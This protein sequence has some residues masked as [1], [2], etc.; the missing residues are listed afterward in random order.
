MNAFKVGRRR[1]ASLAPWGGLAGILIAALV[2][3]R[4][5]VEP[6]VTPEPSPETRPPTVI[7][8]PVAPPPPPPPPPPPVPTGPLLIRVGL[9]SDL[10]S[11]DLACCD[12]QLTL[13]VGD[14]TMPLTG[15]ASITAAGTVTDR[16]VFRLQVAALKDEL[17]AQGLAERLAESTGHE[18]DAVF[19][20]GT[21]L[22]RV[23]VGR[24]AER[25]P[26][27]EGRR[28][29]AVLGLRDVWIA[30]EGGALENPA[31]EIDHDG[32]RY[33]VAGRWLEVSAAEDVGVPFDDNRY[34]GRLL[35]FL[36]S[37]GGLNVVNELK[38]EDYLR[39]VVPKEMG[40]ELYN[41]LEALKAQTVAARTYVVRNLE[42]FAEEGFDICS[43]PRCQVYGGMKVEHP[44]SDRA[45]A[46]T[47]G[48]VVLF[49]GEPA[50]TLYGAT[51][52]GHTE[53]VEVIFPLKNGPYLR[54]TPCLES[55]TNRLAG[56]LP[57]GTPFPGALMQRLVPA[58]RGKPHR[59]LAHRIEQLARLAGLS[60]PRDRLRSLERREVLRF[61]TSVYD[62]AL[63]RRLRS[64]PEV[65]K[66]LLT[67]P[68][69]DLRGRDREL[70]SFLVSSTLLQDPGSETV[71]D[72]EREQLLFR[73]ALY[74]GV[75]ERRSGYFLK[76]SERRLDMRD[77]AGRRASDLPAGLPT[78][79]RQGEDLKAGALELMAGD[80]LDLYLHQGRP[81]A[82]VQPEEVHSVRFGSRAP[83]QRWTR[84]SSTRKLKAAVQ[85]R[86]PGFPFEDFEVL[87]RGVSGRVAK[88]RLLGTG[89]QTL[90]VEG[91]AVRWTLDVWD[92][93]FW[94]E[95]AN[96]S[97]NEEGWRFRGR[98]WG[99]GVGMCQA[100]AFGMAM[101][102][103]SYREIL[104]HYYTG[105][106]LGRLKP[107]PERPRFGV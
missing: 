81:V 57:S 84:F 93:L 101:R 107:S 82:L 29:L 1:A 2:S 18:A 61:A 46:E 53:D 77:S 30:T 72:A 74:L 38:L 16:A 25:E 39:G 52:G 54:G 92:N 97:G 87:S 64:S 19:D 48:Q 27:E 106:E 67:N 62:L 104:G 88:L 55:G 21:D 69:A 28:Q 76:L 83:K 11:L 90:D 12:P 5:V 34:R 63:D 20:A 14:E 85:A 42:E 49:D 43:T 75:L 95:R 79:S 47:A 103:A 96:G 80:R 36:N 3:C 7:R 37:R 60:V 45:V 58:N 68:P 50:E 56:S 40:P 78:F 70:A 8:R 89:G 51:C 6:T 31:L 10:P 44:V 9:D 35:I 59:V 91:L 33:R 13:Q 73:L 26:A 94:A 15:P 4:P 98:G 71:S 86:Y 24:F 100:G 23:R 99:H 65:L 66:E 22:Y 41:Q 32:Q 102:G 105:I 17:Q